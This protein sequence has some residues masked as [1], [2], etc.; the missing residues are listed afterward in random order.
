MQETIRKP[1]RPFLERLGGRF[2][3]ASQLQ[4]LPEADDP[5][6]VLNPVERAG[7]LRVMRGAVLRAAVAGA[8]NA[9][10]TGIGALFAAGVLGH[11]P[12][13]ATWQQHLSYWGLF[14]VLALIA[15]V[16]EI[17]YLY[18]DSLR[19]VR[20]LSRIAGLRID[21][22]ENLDVRF[23]LARA[24][25]ELPNPPDATFGVNPYRESS[26]FQLLFAS[27]VYKAK[28]SVTNFVFKVLVERALGRLVTRSFLAFTAVPINA[29]WNGLVCWFVLREARIRVMGPSAAGEMLDIVFAEQPPPGPRLV[30][31]L[32]RALGAAV[33]RTSELHPNHISLMAE[34]RQRFGAPES[35]IQVDD[36]AAFLRELAELDLG[37]RRTALRVLSIAAILDGRLVKR[38][39]RLLSEAYA[40]A[41]LEPALEHVE[42]LRRAFVAG[43]PIPAQELL[44]SAQ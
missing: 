1:E 24:A 20:E 2:L 42:Q 31:A 8:I 37:E 6:H 7:L 15:A 32:H 11:E 16:L 28:V 19:A 44:A 14:G 39:R 29:L 33:V 40:A 23:A 25:L 35:G 38:E 5:I 26:K 17:L 9:L 36:S 18:W 12:E 30:T 43:D 21:A 3:E 41:K 10:A 4:P 22:A 27:L 13:H 34:L